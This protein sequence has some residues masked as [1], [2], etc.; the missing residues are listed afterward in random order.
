MHHGI[1]SSVTRMVTAGC[2]P[3]DVVLFIAKGLDR[4]PTDPFDNTLFGKIH[5]KG[6]RF[7]IPPQMPKRLSGVHT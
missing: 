6:L 2:E 3:D 4:S 5:G 1:V 7:R